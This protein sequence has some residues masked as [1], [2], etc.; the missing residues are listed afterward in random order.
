[1]M[2]HKANDDAIERRE[3]EQHSV[4]AAAAAA[5]KRA[6]KLEARLSELS[7]TAGGNKQ[8]SDLSVRGV[9]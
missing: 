6:P 3:R 2:L 1:M 8:N 9:I 5:E 4:T 7:R